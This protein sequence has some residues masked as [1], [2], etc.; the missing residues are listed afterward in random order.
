MSEKKLDDYKDLLLDKKTIAVLS[1]SRANK[2]PHATQVWFDCDQDSLKNN[3]IM[4]NTSKGRLKSKLLQKGTKVTLTF[5]DK[6]DDFRYLSAEGEIS[7][8]IEGQEATEHI[9]KLSHKYL[10]KDY[11][12]LQPNEKRLKYIVKVSK[13][14]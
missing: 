4:V 12:Y 8:I 9:H 14:Y 1:V 7:R 5:P 13:I 3:E 11:P 10:G 2:S 6:A